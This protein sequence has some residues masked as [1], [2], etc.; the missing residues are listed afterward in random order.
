MKLKISGDAER[1]V[2]QVFA[3][4][5]DYQSVEDELRS[6]GFEIRRVGKWSE[7]AQGVAWTGRGKVR[8]K[9]RPVAANVAV[10]EPG[11]MIQIDAQ[12]G[13]MQISHETRLVPLGERVTRI[14]VTADLRPSTLSARLIIQSLKLARGR[15]LERM[16]RRLA[17]DIRRV[18]REAS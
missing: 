18:E 15:V 4:L 8:G 7:L 16:E 5:L 17:S 13:G 9:V 6:R 3:V 10:L 14:N 2:D 11:R 1:P 12:V